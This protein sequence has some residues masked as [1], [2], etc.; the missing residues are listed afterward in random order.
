MSGVEKRMPSKTGSAFA[1]GMALILI[2]FS[3]VGNYDLVFNQYQRAYELS[4]WNT[5]EMGNVIHDF[6]DLYGGTNNAYV[7]PYPYWVDT[8]LVGMNAGDPTRDYATHRPDFVY[9]ELPP[10]QDVPG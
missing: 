2:F 10:T 7:V 8:R 1:W 3:A 9:T 4:S 6:G 5:S